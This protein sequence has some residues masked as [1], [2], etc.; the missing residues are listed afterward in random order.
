MLKSAADETLSVQLQYLDNP[1]FPAKQVT[2]TTT[3]VAN[4]LTDKKEKDKPL[5][6]LSFA[7]LL[8][9]IFK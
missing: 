4:A 5:W 2:M 6:F 3:T 8:F 9:P 1:G 7:N